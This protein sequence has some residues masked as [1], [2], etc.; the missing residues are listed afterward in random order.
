MAP[1][2]RPLPALLFAVLLGVLGGGCSDP[3][4][5][6]QLSGLLLDA[7][8]QEV[9]G[10]AVSRRHPDTLWMLNDGG[11][12]AQL[13]AVSRRGSRLAT[14]RIDGVDNTD[15]EDL[16][17]FEL[18]GRHYLLIADTGDNGGL[19]RT[20]QL[21]AIE[22]PATLAD[23]TLR[24]AW[25]IVFRWPDGARDCEAVAVDAAAG[26]ILLLSKRRRPPELFALPLRPRDPG[27]QVARALGTLAGVPQADAEEVR[28]NPRLARIRSQVTAADLAP[29]S[30]AM[31]VLT[32]RDVLVYP[33]RNRE[34]WAQALAR[35]PQVHPLPWLPQAEALA[36]SADSR[37]LYA[38]GELSP[39]PLLY[40]NP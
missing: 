31:A 7:H 18:D 23:A 32:Y 3:P 2:L 5:F 34:S 6:A 12:P 33:R 14:L 20:L 35:P 21:H 13:Y 22:E 10:L 36:W 28:A 19:R 26:Q 40:L 15:W 9:S 27:L 1:R 4:P 16:A 30:H 25:S 11:N 39:A 24:P 29:D 8:L 37:A 38:T 17:A